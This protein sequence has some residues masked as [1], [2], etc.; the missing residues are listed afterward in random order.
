MVPDGSK[1]A[2]K[3]IVSI[4]WVACCG[5]VAASEKLTDAVAFQQRRRAK[6]READAPL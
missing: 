4:L 2:S 1:I 6:A 5:P 3:Y